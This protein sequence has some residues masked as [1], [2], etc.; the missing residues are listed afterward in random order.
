MRPPTRVTSNV[1]LVEPA[2]HRRAQN[3]FRRADAVGAGS[4]VEHAVRERQH[5]VDVVG[6]EENGG[7]V[8]AAALI[9]ETAHFALVVQVQADQRLV[10]QQDRRLGDQRLSDPQALLLTAGELADRPVGEVAACTAS[11]ARLH[12]LTDGS[13]PSRRRPKTVTVDA[14]PHEIA[15]THRCSGRKQPLL[16]HVADVPVAPSHP[17]SRHCDLARGQ[18]LQAE[19]GLEQRRSCLSRWRPRR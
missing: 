1:R 4:Q 12:P 17:P 19:D 13:W 7:A 3:L 9:D 18:R 14:E 15:P 10:A 16:R 5:G 11:I 6:D 8:A 2:E